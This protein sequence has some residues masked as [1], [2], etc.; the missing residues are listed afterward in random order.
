MITG[1]KHSLSFGTDPVADDVRATFRSATFHHADRSNADPASSGPLDID[2]LY[3]NLAPATER[4]GI[5]LILAGSLAAAV[6]SISHAI[7]SL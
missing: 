5:V 1:P 2:A 7:A 6:R 3:P 4:H